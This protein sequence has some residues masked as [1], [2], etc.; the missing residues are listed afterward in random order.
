MNK[1]SAHFGYPNTFSNKVQQKLLSLVTV[2]VLSL[3]LFSQASVAQTEQT[4][5][6]RQ[7]AQLAEYIGVDYASAVENGE[8][9][10]EGEYHEMLEFS[11]II[12][13]RISTQLEHENKAAIYQQSLALEQAIK[14]K[15]T[16][17][18][19][20]QLSADMRGQ[21]LAILP[22]SLLPEQL[23]STERTQQLFQENCSS[24]HGPSGQGDGILAKGLSPEP[25]NFTDRER[26][27]NRSLLG[28]FDAISNGLDDTA[29]PAFTQLKEQERWSLAFYA[30][31]LAFNADDSAEKPKDLA[32]Q[33]WINFNPSQLI[34]RDNNINARLY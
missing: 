31:S 20:R 18:H 4:S 16:V 26:A 25:T 27:M 8:V 5:Q 11:A 34:N 3:S 7:L 21:F 14:D 1:R 12:A 30:G 17:S 15:S 10:N 23:L 29:M 9:V 6:L 28:L 13:K 19:I 24:C 33:N 22:D 2:I 32:F